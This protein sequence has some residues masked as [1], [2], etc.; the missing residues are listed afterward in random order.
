MKL[1][2][3]TILFSFLL[4]VTSMLVTTP[5]FAA[6][7]YYTDSSH[8][9]VVAEDVT[10]EPVEPGQDLTVKIRLINDGGIAAEDVSLRLN[11]EYP[12]FIK[13]ESNNFEDKK[14]LCVDCSIDNTYYLVV[15]AN[16]KSGL[17]PL[18]FEIYEGDA[19]FEPDETINI[20]V[21]GKPDVILQASPLD[22]KVSSGDKFTMT[23]DAKNVGT[24]VA[25]NVK[26]TPQSDDILML[27]SN[28]KLID[29]IKPEK[30]LSFNLDFIVKETLAP[31]T[32]KFPIT[33]E[34]VDEQGSSYETNFEMGINVLE[35]SDIDIQ[36]L[37]INPPFPTLVDEVHMEGIVEN[38][39]TG[40]AD[41][42]VVELITQNNKTYKAFIG[43]LES[44]DD[45]P[46]YFNVKPEAVGLQTAMLKITYTDDFG[47]HSFETSIEKDV[48]R[49]TNNLI[50]IIVVLLLV[51][52]VVGYFY[53]KKRKS[54]K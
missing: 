42:V 29:E 46:F 40:D 50:T 25:R 10:P 37:K 33:L 11:A 32:Y 17:Y 7:S 12:F 38:T 41:S 45:A 43:Q 14:S 16:A 18:N 1:K 3:G 28:I 6:S 39:G 52:L 49:P 53:L 8:L 4:I 35:R 15:D 22:T 27:G 21:I 44:D 34:Y 30:S 24:G 31:D 2:Y 13:T 9:K 5:V 26:I 23:F 51:I 19:I 47:E 54:K 20:S 36:S 48:K